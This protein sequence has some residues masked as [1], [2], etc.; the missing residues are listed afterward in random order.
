MAKPPRKPAPANRPA[1]ATQAGATLSLH[2]FFGNLRLQSL[3]LFALAFVLYANTLGHGFTQDDAIVI[4]DNK[5]TK[6]G[7]NGIPDIFRND[8]FYGFFKVEGKE[9]LV[10][11]GRYRPLTLAI[12]AL[13]YQIFGENAFGFH[14]LT[15]LLFACTCVVLYRSLLLLLTP[16]FGEAYAALTAWMAAMLFAVHPIH[17][18]VVANVKGCDEIVTLLCSFGALWLMVKSF[19]GGTARLKPALLNVLSGL[20]F[21][22]A[23]LSKENAA[24]FVVVA[25]LALWFF[26]RPNAGQF[27]RH[28]APLW[29]AF[30]VFFVLR[31]NILRWEFGAEP[32]ELMN[33]PFLKIQGDHWVKFTFSERLASIF[34]TLWKYIQLLFVP[35]PLTHDYYPRHIGLITFGKPGAW[36]GLTVYAALA[37]YAIA[38]LRRRDPVR[39]GILYYLLTLSIV[40][41]LV[42]PIGTNMGERFAFMPSVGFCLIISVLIVQLLREGKGWNPKKITLPLGILGAIVLV[43]AL[44]TLLRNPVWLSNE[45]LFFTDVAISGESA[46]IRNACGGVLFDKARVEKDENT[47]RSYCNQALVHLNKALQIYPNYKDA[48][49]SR[50]GCQLLLHNYEGAIADYRLAVQL[51][52]T[53]ARPRTTLA[54]ALREAG[55]YAGEQ[56]GDLTTALKYLAEAWQLNPKDAEIARLLGVANGVQGKSAEALQW[57]QKAADLEPNNAIVL[58]DLGTAYYIAGDKAKGEEY[59]QKAMQLDPS[60]K[61][62]K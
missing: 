38:G 19:D 41:N 8:T 15:V 44:K 55:K 54:I 21:F 43:F 37:V 62:R 9:T 20:V 53:D 48:L 42:F 16:R 6:K 39:F 18:E 45:K 22:L 2:P 29:I 4:T 46:K 58:F 31:G 28:V 34:Y 23:C 61:S 57:F 27:I 12:F 30:L 10:S 25:P 40:S 1:A 32:L 49:L 11:G 59:H 56:K 5:F 51:A 3:L 13:L 52:G 26:R 7:L 33:N 50:G 60:L 24:T 17:T 14:L 47:M 35:H 36:L